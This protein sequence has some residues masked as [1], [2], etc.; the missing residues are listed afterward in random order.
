MTLA[1]IQ[2][3]LKS[4]KYLLSAEVQTTAVRKTIA[5]ERFMSQFVSVWE[6]SAE[7]K[8]LTTPVLVL[9]LVY[10]YYC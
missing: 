9:P 1:L 2:M 8:A 6:N 7:N 10:R 5:T 4:I 3:A